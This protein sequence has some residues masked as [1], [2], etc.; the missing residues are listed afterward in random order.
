VEGCNS[1][2]KKSKDEAFQ[3]EDSL[4]YEKWLAAFRNGPDSEMSEGYEFLR[5][6]HATGFYEAYDVVATYA[7]KSQVEI[8][9]FM[10]KRECG[11]PF[12]NNNY[13]ELESICTYCNGFFSYMDSIPCPSPGCSSEFCSKICLQDHVG[14]RHI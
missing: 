7:E 11:Y 14:F 6:F 1:T 12:V 4:P 13:P 10:E 2:N 3:E 9:W 8:L 5:Q